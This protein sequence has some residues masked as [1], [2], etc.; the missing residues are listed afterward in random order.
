MP[1]T[2]LDACTGTRVTIDVPVKPQPIRRI[3]RW[4]RQELDRLETNKKPSMSRA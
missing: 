2:I 3:R 1:L 4:I